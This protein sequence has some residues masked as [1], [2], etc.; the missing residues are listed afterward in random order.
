MLFYPCNL[1]IQKTLLPIWNVNI[2]EITF[3]LIVHHQLFEAHV[4]RWRFSLPH[5]Y[6]QKTKRKIHQLSHPWSCSNLEGCLDFLETHQLRIYSSEHWPPLS[7]PFPREKGRLR[8]NT[9]LIKCNFLK[10]GSSHMVVFY[11]YSL[12]PKNGGE[13]KGKEIISNI[14]MVASSWQSYGYVPFPHFIHIYT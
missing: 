4:G 2:K 9:A 1:S 13:K 6:S 14:N 10:Q 5:Y 11:H 3:S 12:H 8:F 7:D